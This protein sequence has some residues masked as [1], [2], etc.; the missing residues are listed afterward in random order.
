M[1]RH[2]LV[3]NDFPPKVGGIQSYLYELWR[4]LEPGRAVVLTAS[5]HEDAAVFDRESALTIERAESST[6]FAPSPRA[7]RAVKAAIERHQ[8]DLVLFDPAWPLGLLGPFL[9]VPYGV[10]VHGAEVTIPG[11]LPV[12]A[13]TMRSVLSRARVVVAAG[14]YP[15]IQSR[16]IAADRLPP[17]LQ[18]PPGVD[19]ERFRPLDAATRARVRGELAI[20]DDEF[21]LVTYSRLVPRKGFDTLIRASARLAPRY[22]RLRV[23]VGGSGRDRRRLEALAARLRAPVHFLGRVD[24]E[25]LPAWLGAGD[26]FAMDCRS[27]WLG[28]EAEGFGIVFLEA[29]AAGLA[30]IAGRSGGSSEAVEHGETGLVLDNPHSVSALADA[31]AS[32]MDDD[33]T[34]A[35]LAARAR[36]FV[37][38][39]FTWD[40]VAARL[41]QELAPFDHFDSASSVA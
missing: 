25:A 30:A 27:R 8:P 17:V 15:E 26:L 6:F 39:N 36:D 10:I 20:G 23:Y 22:P 14:H 16:R 13:A 41:S 21:A 11:H 1:A 32:L 34:R 19:I 37:A 28:L 5:S 3:T 38:E 24:D 33:V 4:R 2:L 18:I 12:A 35:R 29:E 40:A 7:L 31:I 9:S